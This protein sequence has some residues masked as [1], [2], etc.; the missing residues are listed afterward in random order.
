VS[1]AARIIHPYR[2]VQ[3]IALDDP[4]I[5]GFHRLRRPP[6]G[7]GVFARTFCA[8]GK[9]GRVSPFGNGRLIRPVPLAAIAL[10]LYHPSATVGRVSEAQP[11]TPGGETTDGFRYA[12]LVLQFGRAPAIKSLVR[13]GSH[14]KSALIIRRLAVTSSNV[15]SIVTAKENDHATRR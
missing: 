10:P 1:A 6:P 12:S 3:T 15:C 11:A 8:S 14:P 4:T 7:R 2:I 5:L 9:P 13:D